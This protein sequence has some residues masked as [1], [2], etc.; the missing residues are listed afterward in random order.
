MSQVPIFKYPLDLTGS[1]PGNLVTYELVQLV[2]TSGNRTIVPK[3]GAFYAASMKIRQ[4]GHNIDAN[5]LS[6]ID[7]SGATPFIAPLHVPVPGG[8][9]VVLANSPG[10]VQYVNLSNQLITTEN[11]LYTYVVDNGGAYTLTRTTPGALLVP[12][13]DY[14]SFMLNQDATRMSGGKFVDQL[15]VLT[16][17]TIQGYIILEYQA[18][19]GIF[20]VAADVLQLLIQELDLDNR[21]VNWHDIVELPP[22]FNPVPH[23]HHSSEYFGYGGLISAIERMYLA[24]VNLGDSNFSLNRKVFPPIL[25]HAGAV[26]ETGVSGEDIKIADG[27][28]LT[29]LGKIVPRIPSVYGDEYKSIYKLNYL[30]SEPGLN[31]NENYYS[32]EGELLINFSQYFGNYLEIKDIIT[33]GQGHST[34]QF[35]IYQ[36]TREVIDE[37]VYVDAIYIFELSKGN[38]APLLLSTEEIPELITFDNGYNKIVVGVDTEIVFDGNTVPVS[39]IAPSQFIVTDL[40][41]INNNASTSDIFVQFTVL[42]DDENILLSDINS[43]LMDLISSMNSTSQVLESKI[44]VISELAPRETIANV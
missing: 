16:N 35:V 20:S 1:H 17:Q 41:D 38:R 18:V 7:L 30:T 23:Y 10:P 24:V 13:T 29:Y 26:Y 32:V 14:K 44:N 36:K 2:N 6:N 12:G 8:D 15:M 27:S 9:P 22:G 28:I 3:Y 4:V 39:V 34:S 19:G 21:P 42:N 33:S 40:G 5:A 31:P 37:D 11:G 43:T 25:D